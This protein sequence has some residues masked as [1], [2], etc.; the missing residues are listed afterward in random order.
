M[1]LYE[2]LDSL[3]ISYTEIEHP[4]VFTVEEAQQIKREIAGIGCKNLFLKDKK[5]HYYLVVLEESKKA[6]LKEISHLPGISHL[7]F[8]NEQEL[9]DILGL[10]R[11]SV[12]PLGILNDAEHKVTLIID[13]SLQN[14]RVLIHPNTN[15]KTLSMDFSDLI[16]FIEHEGNSYILH[17]L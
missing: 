13:E 9:S 7:S 2:I 14:Q 11:G 10:T 5:H 3:H 12:T 15:T 16:R 8:A 1:N 17:E 6:N 4:P